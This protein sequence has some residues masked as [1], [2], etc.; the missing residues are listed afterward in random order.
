MVVKNTDLQLSK[1]ASIL[2]WFKGLGAIKE[3]IDNLVGVISEGSSE[4]DKGISQT[5]GLMERSGKDVGFIRFLQNEGD[6]E[7]SGAA[8][9]MEAQHGHVMGQI[10]K[11]ADYD[12][13][14]SKTEIAQYASLVKNAANSGEGPAGR[15][16]RLGLGMATGDLGSWKT[17]AMGTVGYDP[18]RTMSSELEYRK[19]N[20]AAVEN[21]V[22]GG[23]EVS[24]KERAEIANMNENLFL[25]ARDA[26]KSIEDS[27]GRSGWISY[28]TEQLSEWWSSSNEPT[29]SQQ[30][31]Y[32]R[33]ANIR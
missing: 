11:M 32:L 30:P 1:L 17:A 16:V 3:A 25:N 26:V 2:K 23:L 31:D 9:E 29:Y 27:D 18:I 28:Y 19:A 20:I 14:T 4:M 33:W 8:F 24:Q 21:R 13:Q 7:V 22:R 12:E 15:A 6:D 10:N 5:E